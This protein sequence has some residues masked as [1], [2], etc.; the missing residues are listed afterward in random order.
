MDG[1]FYNDI[2]EP[3]MAADPAAVTLSTTN[4]ALIPASNLPVMG[5]Q[6]FARVVAR[7]SPSSTCGAAN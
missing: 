3:F 2:R 1:A 5:G 7:L 4:L 6:Y